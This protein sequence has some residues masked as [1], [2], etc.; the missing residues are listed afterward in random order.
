MWGWE[1]KFFQ[2]CFRNGVDPTSQIR[3][4]DDSEGVT[5]WRLRVKWFAKR[6]LDGMTICAWRIYAD[7]RRNAIS[8]ATVPFL[9][10]VLTVVL[11]HRFAR[12]DFSVLG[13]FERFMNSL[14][15]R[16]IVP[17]GDDAYVIAQVLFGV[18]VQLI[19]IYTMIP[20]GVFLL[21]AITKMMAVVLWVVLEVF[22]VALY[23][24]GCRLLRG[25]L[26]RLD[27]DLYQHRSV[28]VFLGGI[29]T[30]ISVFAVGTGLAVRSYRCRQKHARHTCLDI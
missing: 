10:G 27:I 16:D 29:L 17:T 30:S 22:D 12:P 23:S 21:L 24:F 19:V 5:S 6:R 14:V 28:A 3:K 7:D 20:M 25:M 9:I 26:R 18:F 1:R 15:F 4:V 11:V 13:S 8:L 2:L